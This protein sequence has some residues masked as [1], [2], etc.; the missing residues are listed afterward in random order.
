MC[1]GFL[2]PPT[3]YQNVDNHAELE[4]PGGEKGEEWVVP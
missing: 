3:P 1:R 4:R 2:K